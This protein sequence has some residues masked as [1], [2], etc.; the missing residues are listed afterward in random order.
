MYTFSEQVN[1][2]TVCIHFFPLLFR[3]L[4]IV[5]IDHIYFS[6]QEGLSF[7]IKKF[8]AFMLILCT[9]H[10]INKKSHIKENV[11][12]FIL[13]IFQF[14]YRLTISL[15]K[16]LFPEIKDCILT[17]RKIVNFTIMMLKPPLP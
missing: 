4:F 7:V 12:H 11:K 17:I 8:F 3:I 14:T 6:M 2:V 9:F 16:T 5:Q 13:S 10:I 1:C 15:I